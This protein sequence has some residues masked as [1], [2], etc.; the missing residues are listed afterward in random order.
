MSDQMSDSKWKIAMSSP[1]VGSSGVGGSSIRPCDLQ[2]YANPRRGMTG[3]SDKSSSPAST[4]RKAHGANSSPRTPTRLSRQL[5]DKLPPGVPYKEVEAAKSRCEECNRTFQRPEHLT[6]HKKSSAHAADYAPFVCELE[7]CRTKDGQPR[8]F[9]RR[10]NHKA[11]VIKV[12]LCPA[13][14]GRRERVT[15][16]EACRLGWDIYF[17]A[18]AKEIAK[19][20]SLLRSKLSSSV[21]SVSRTSSTRAIKKENARRSQKLLRSQEDR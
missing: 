15:R 8:R 4:K 12:H 9:N 1:Q 18:A 2:T 5:L 20:A 14:K 19:Q 13:A 10:D 11:H 6:R 16:E 7:R 3:V 21:F 17:E